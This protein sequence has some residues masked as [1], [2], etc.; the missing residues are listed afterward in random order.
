MKGLRAAL[1]RMICGRGDR[2]LRSIRDPYRVM[3]RLL[4]GQRVTAILDAGAGH[5]RVS[6][7]LLALFPEARVF[8]FE[9]NPAYR[10]TLAALA[11]R[12][13]RF[14]P[15]FAALA[16]R[17]GE[18]DLRVMCSPGNTSLFRPGSSL[19][20]VDPEGAR[21]ER[22]IRVGTVSLDRWAEEQAAPPMQ[23]LKFDIQGAELEALKGAA[24]ILRETV[25]LVYSEVFFNPLYRGGA[26]F[27]DIDGFLREHG[28]VLHD[29]YKPKYHPS[30]Q[31]LW[32]NAIYVDPAKCPAA[33]AHTEARA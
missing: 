29:L 3:A 32:A 4:A 7:R 17:Y 21:L 18:A 28:F 22:V 24:G 13:P 33:G 27:A 5:G 2:N 6:R 30:G 14:T 16:A 25:V 10:Q 1:R 26:L 19:Q 15:L 12:N 8:A 31:I 23:I 11:E 20:A 9:P